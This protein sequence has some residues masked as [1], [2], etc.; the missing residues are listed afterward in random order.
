MLVHVK[1]RHVPGMAA[2]GRRSRSKTES[3]PH[4]DKEPLYQLIM[5]T[6]PILLA[7]LA[8]C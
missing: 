6:G 7:Y 1:G 2:D 5:F 4:S 8:F 3:P